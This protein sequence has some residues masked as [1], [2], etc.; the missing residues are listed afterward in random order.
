V[1]HW[2]IVVATRRQGSSLN[3]SGSSHVLLPPLLWGWH[4]RSTANQYQTLHEELFHLA[5]AF[6]IVSWGKIYIKSPCVHVWMATHEGY[7]MHRQGEVRAAKQNSP[8]MAATISSLTMP[9]HSVSWY[10]IQSY[11]SGRKATKSFL[12]AIKALWGEG[13]SWSKLIP[14][15]CQRKHYKYAYLHAR[16][17]EMRFSPFAQQACPC[18]IV[19]TNRFPLFLTKE[20]DKGGLRDFEEQV[21]AVNLKCLNSS[22]PDLF[23][24]E[25]PTC[26]SLCAL[27]LILP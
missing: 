16:N 24:W 10:L 8:R 9:W 27:C 23:F 19:S 7:S 13:E 5:S 1:V 11:T 12:S 22:T 17:I 2:A 20:L 6:F 25:F 4:A 14:N 26:L 3:I 18:S 21:A 15:Q